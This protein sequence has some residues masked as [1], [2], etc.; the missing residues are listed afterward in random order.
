MRTDLENHLV[1]ALAL[2][3][4]LVA[5]RA[6]LERWLRQHWPEGQSY[7]PAENPGCGTGLVGLSFFI[8]AMVGNQ[9]WVFSV[10]VAAFAWAMIRA[11]RRD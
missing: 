4:G 11:G 2:A 3:A 7:T 10:V 8:G 6:L 1:E 9:W 5:V